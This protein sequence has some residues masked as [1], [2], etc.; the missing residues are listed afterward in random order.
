M[1]TYL[2]LDTTT[3]LPK[4]T[5]P[6]TI[7]A[8]A[9]DAGKIIQL[10]SAGKIDVTVLPTGVGPAAFSA[11]AGEALAARDF[12]YVSATGTILKADGT[13]PVKKAVGFVTGAVSNAAVGTVFYGDVV[14]GFTGLTPGASYFLSHTTT[15]AV[16]LAASLTTTA[17]RIVQLLGTAKSATELIVEIQIPTIL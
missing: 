16:V 14:S 10:D 6:V 1:A 7:S 12:V 3:G 4:R 8:G 9:G 11:T 5:V 15:G 13:D 2:D 17:G